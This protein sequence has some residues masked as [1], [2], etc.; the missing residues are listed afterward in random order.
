MCA[1]THTELQIPD[2]NVNK[3]NTN[4]SYAITWVTDDLNEFKITYDASAYKIINY[5]STKSNDNSN[6]GF[7]YNI[8]ETNDGTRRAYTFEIVNKKGKEV[9]YL[10][11]SKYKAHF[12]TGNHWI[13]FELPDPDATY[14]ITLNSDGNYEAEITTNLTGLKFS[15]VGALNLQV[16]TIQF[17]VISI[18]QIQNLFQVTTCRVDTGSVLM[19]GLFFLIAFGLI[20]AGFTTNIGFIGVFGAILLWIN[21]WFV[22]PCVAII[23]TLLT[24]LAILFFFYFIFR[25]VFPNLFSPNQERR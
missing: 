23:A 7:T 24:F 14:I 2:W 17:E 8:N 18:P 4:D 6:Y 16:A 19:L 13:D 22:A 21:S 9:Y 3:E 15:S 1:D 5:S 25:G 11:D 20:M 12:I 10:P